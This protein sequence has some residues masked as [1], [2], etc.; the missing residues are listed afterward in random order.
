MDSQGESLYRYKFFKYKKICFA[1]LFPV[2]K[3]YHYFRRKLGR[4]F[5]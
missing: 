4:L 3:H 5:K 2:E 1:I